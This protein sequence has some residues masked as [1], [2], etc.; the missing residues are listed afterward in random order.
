[1][2]LII[3]NMNC[4]GT[5]NVVG[6]GLGWLFSVPLQMKLYSISSVVA[7]FLHGFCAHT[8]AEWVQN[9][10]MTF[11]VTVRGRYHGAGADGAER[12]RGEW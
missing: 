3:I 12:V 9:P 4:R 1:M 2:Y 10:T 8:C 6:S 11:S 5:E 7:S